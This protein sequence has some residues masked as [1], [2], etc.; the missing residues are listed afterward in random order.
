MFDVIA[1]DAD[2]TLW[3]NETL[4]RAT[5][6]KFIQL[7][8]RYR[9]AEA[10]EEALHAAE[11]RNLQRFGYGIKGFALSMIETAIELSEGRI[12]GGD[13]Q[14]II[15]FAKEMI[16]APVRLFE[17]AQETVAGLSASHDL[18]LITKGDLLDQE[19]KIARSGLGGY[20]TYVEIVSQKTSAVYETLL[21]KHSIDPER[22]LMVGNSLKS[23][24][25]PVVAI[26]GQAVYIPYDLTWVHEIVGDHDG[27]EQRRYF[28]LEHIG[29]LPDLVR[30]VGD[31][32]QKS[33]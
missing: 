21:A 1:F 11:V 14:A 4:Y 10:I 29:L 28:E 12:Q 27:D 20:F 3:H 7:L 6:D 33:R 30:R 23:D 22:F 8:S 13:I 15:D 9:H 31:D 17:H 18:M 32:P 2:D 19:T 26:G 24:I 25:L 5:E 16:D